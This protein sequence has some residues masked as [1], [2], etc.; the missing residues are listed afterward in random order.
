MKKNIV[1][2][3]FN[4][5]QRQHYLLEKQYSFKIKPRLLYSGILKK[6]KNW[7][8][9]THSHNFVEI[10]FVVDGKGTLTVSYTHLDVYKRQ[11]FISTEFSVA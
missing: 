11:T 10:V 5:N 7:H 2:H 8:D 9:N 4:S 6:M 3:R 1:I